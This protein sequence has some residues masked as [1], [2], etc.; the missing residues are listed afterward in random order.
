MVT[1]VT[2]IFHPLITP[3]TTYTY[4]TGSL[5]SDP[6]SATD[7]DRLPPGG[8]ALSDAF[9]HWFGR[10]KQSALS[11]VKS[12]RNVSSSHDRDISTEHGRPTSQETGRRPPSD[13]EGP[14]TSIIGVLDYVKRAFDDDELLDGLPLEAAVNLGAWK[15][16]RAHRRDVLQQVGN[17]QRSNEQI[18]MARKHNAGHGLQRETRRPDEWSWDGV[19]KER[20]KKGVDASISDQILFGHGDDTVGLHLPFARLGYWL[21]SGKRSVS[22]T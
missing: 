16:W 10:S 18:S 15:A 20:V 6:V 4:T 1:F 19:W 9:P 13:P 22:L 14:R 17:S 8:F 11:S 3:L 12:S 7:E 2:D 5:T 21:T